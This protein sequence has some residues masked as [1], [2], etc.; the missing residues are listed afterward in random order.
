MDSTSWNP[1]ELTFQPITSTVSGISRLRVASD[2]R[3]VDVRWDR[4]GRESAPGGHH[5]GRAVAEQAHADQR[6]DRGVV[7]LQCQRA[8]LDR[9]QH[10]HVAGE[11]AQVVVD[12]R[13][14]GST[15]HASEAEQ[16]DAL[17]VGPQSDRA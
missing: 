3:T 8:Q 14:A 5:R 17:D 16:R 2:A 4:P 12:A 13:H 10:R 9:Q 15:C 6:G 1:L 11:A 7:A